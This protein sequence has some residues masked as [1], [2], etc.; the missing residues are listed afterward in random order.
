M[1]WNNHDTP[2]VV[3]RWGNESKYRVQS[4]KMFAILLHLMKGTPYIYQGEEI[5]MTNR[6]ITD[7]SQAEDIETINMYHERLEKGYTKEAILRSINAKG[8][9]NARTPMQWNSEAYGGFSTETPWLEVNP[10]YKEINVKEALENEHSIFYT[11]RKLIQL[12]KKNRIV[13]L[14]DFNLL[15]ED[16]P[17]IFAY[18]RTYKQTT[19]LVVAN[20]SEEIVDICLT[21]EKQN[22]HV[23][24]SNIAKN[25]YDLSSL[26]LS[27]YETFVAER[28]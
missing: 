16:H 23:L 26:K 17:Q 24:L 21:K 7:I 22:V 9:D 1:V 8:R 27:P 18:E 25:T 19:W 5:G 10:N 12:R 6:T 3:S 4:A 14:G 28:P 13:E 2:R 11:Y 20:F 15:L